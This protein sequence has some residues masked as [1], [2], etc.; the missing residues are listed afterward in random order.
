MD[1]WMNGWMDEWMNG[2]MDEW[3]DW[4]M[5][6]KKLNLNFRSADKQRGW[7]CIRRLQW[8]DKKSNGWIVTHWIWSK[9]LLACSLKSSRLHL[10]SLICLFRAFLLL[11]LARGLRQ[12][13]QPLN[14]L[15]S[16]LPQP[17]SLPQ[18]WPGRPWAASISRWDYPQTQPTPGFP[19]SGRRAWGRQASGW[20]P[21]KKVCFRNEWMDWLIAR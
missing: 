3:M 7:N 13:G 6:N 9:S 19:G 11:N 18:F 2:W 20:W 12:I 17:S 16:R 5:D 21:I 8:L 15:I 1:E 10:P 4:F 14:S